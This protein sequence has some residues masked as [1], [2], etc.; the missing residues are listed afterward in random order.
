MIVFGLLLLWWSTRSDSTETTSTTHSP[1]RA[2]AAQIVHVESV[3]GTGDAVGAGAEQPDWA[4]WECKRRAQT[5]RWREC[6]SW[7]TYSSER[8]GACPGSQKCCPPDPGGSREEPPIVE[9]DLPPDRG[10]D[11]D[12]EAPPT[13]HQRE[14]DERRREIETEIDELLG[15]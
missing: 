10:F 14:R 4:E 5:N 7:R 15:E 6:L 1:R 2:V 8:S 9:P 11:L 3:C 12:E 13:E